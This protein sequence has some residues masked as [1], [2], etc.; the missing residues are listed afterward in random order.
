MQAQGDIAMPVNSNFHQRASN[1]RSRIKSFFFLVL[2]IIN[3][4]SAPSVTAQIVISTV[5]DLQNIVT[6][7]S[8]SYVINNDIDAGGNSFSPI[9]TP[10][11]PFTGTL[12]GRGHAISN[13]NITMP[14]TS[15]SS[16][17]FAGL[18]G[19]IGNS[20]VVKNVR[21]KSSSVILQTRSDLNYSV[22]GVAGV[23]TGT[24]TQSTYDGVITISGGAAT[25]IIGG[26]VGNNGGIVSLSRADVNITA[27]G[28][29]TNDLYVGG[30]AGENCCSETTVNYIAFSSAAGI[31]SS[32]NAIGLNMVGGLVG[33]NG[34]N[35][36][37]SFSD[38]AVIGGT[39]AMA[40]GLV[41]WDA[42]YTQIKRASAFGPVKA[43]SSS[44]VGGFVGFLQDG[45]ISNSYSFG[46][47]AGGIN[48]YVGGMA[49]YI[50]GSVANS[51]STGAPSNPSGGAVGGLVGYSGPG[52]SVSESYWDKNTSHVTVSA[53][54]VGLTTA[55][56]TALKLPHGLEETDWIAIAGPTKGVKRYYPQLWKKSF[57][58]SAFPLGGQTPYKDKPSGSPDNSA[59][60]ISVLD[61]AMQSYAEPGTARPYGCDG[62][63]LSF[64]GQQGQWQFGTD[65]H[66]YDPHVNC[67]GLALGYAQ[68]KNK[69]PFIINGIDYVGCCGGLSYLNYEGHTGID[70]VAAYV[71]VYAA[72]SGIV[73]YPW[74]AVGMSGNDAYCRFHA[75]AEVPDQ[76]AA[77]RLYYL[78]LK[79]HPAV[80]DSPSPPYCPSSDSHNSA[81][82]SVSF[83]PD[84]NCHY[85]MNGVPFTPTVLP[86]PE[87]THVVSGCQIAISGSAGVGTHAHLHFEVQQMLPTKQLSVDPSALRAL[88]C[89]D[90]ANGYSRT[91]SNSCMPIDPYGWAGGATSCVGPP[92]SWTGD[93]YKCFATTPD[94]PNGLVSVGLWGE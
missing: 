77:Y 61:H 79:T 3:F 39:S 38:S 49:G 11:A 60:V 7:L 25:A 42:F 9:G 87:G 47:A 13:L 73:F 26:L 55:K 53:G 18:F 84:P 80:L 19:Y 16:S 35:I 27:T 45:G 34:G 10:T 29:I 90:E 56:L 76:A 40:G 62:T 89:Y 2:L 83:S 8:G 65:P 15:D 46:D 94:F 66:G 78:H 48:S 88:Q 4:L 72:D 17:Y 33:L 1:E 51:Y 22:G 54:G 43:G 58:L 81:G 71:P 21:L 12:D 64:T 68:D 14:S 59:Q 85:T 32:K 57:M 69:T 23:S 41:G 28:E 37:L 30:L 6:D 92:S 63:I 36:D 93:T 82:Q 70:Y 86:L 74:S 31:V 24:L 52:G 75:L 67:A 44:E 5:T 20:G 91:S 50:Q